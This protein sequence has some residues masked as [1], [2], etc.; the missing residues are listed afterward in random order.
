MN[1]FNLSTFSGRVLLALIF[2]ISGFG[3]LADPSGTIAYI[4]SVGA[5]A[6]ELA[7]G[8]ALIVELGLGL[9]L[10]LGYHAKISAL[11]IAGFTLATGFLFHFDFGNQIQTIMFLKNLAITGGLLQIVAHGAGGFSLDGARR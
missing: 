3:K 8:V 9:A 10:L 1:T 6:P 5:P 4:A 7:Y 11:L 2:V